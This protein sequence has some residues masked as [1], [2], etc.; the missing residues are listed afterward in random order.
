MKNL[1]DLIRYLKPERE[2]IDEAFNR[3]LDPLVLVDEN[4]DIND[5]FKLSNLTH[6]LREKLRDPSRYAP[7][8]IDINDPF[9]IYYDASSNKYYNKR[10]LIDSNGNETIQFRRIRPEGNNPAW[11]EIDENT[12][13]PIELTLGFSFYYG[14]NDDK[15]YQEPLDEVV[16]DNQF[17]YNPKELET[18][19]DGEV[20]EL[21]YKDYEGYYNDFGD[22]LLKTILDFSLIK[23]ISSIEKR[24]VKLNFSDRIGYVL[25]YPSIYSNSNNTKIKVR[26]TYSNIKRFFLFFLLSKTAIKLEFKSIYTYLSFVNAT[27]FEDGD[28]NDK[29]YFNTS[30]RYVKAFFEDYLSILDKEFDRRKNNITEILKLI[31]FTPPVYLIRKDSK[32][33]WEILERSLKNSVTNNGTNKEDAVIKIIKVLTLIESPDS[34]LDQLFERKIGSNSFFYL[35]Y[36]KINGENFDSYIAMI[37]SLWLKSSYS[38]NIEEKKYPK[39]NGPIYLSYTSN[40]TLGFYYSNCDIDYNKKQDLLDISLETGRYT[41]EYQDRGKTGPQLVRKEIILDYKYHPLYPIIIPNLEEQKTEIKLKSIVPAFYL[42]ANEDR[43]FWSNV[44]TTGEYALDIASTVSGVGNIYK[45]RHLAKVAARAN[46]LKNTTRAA[47][48]ANT[49]SKVQ[50]ISGLVEVSSGSINTLLKLLELEDSPIGK[51]IGEV[52]FWLEMASLTG[53]LSQGIRSGLRKSSINLLS[54]KEALDSFVQKG[55]L[56]AKKQKELIEDIILILLDKV[57]V[58]FLKYQAT[59]ELL[60]SLKVTISRNIDDLSS[61]PGLVAAGADGSRFRVNYNNLNILEGTKDDINDFLK[62]IDDISKSGGNVRKKITNKLDE[63][64][65]ELNNKYRDFLETNNLKIERPKGGRSNIQLVD[66]KNEDINFYGRPNE[67]E[68]F[69]RLFNN[70]EEKI[71]N[72]NI[73]VKHFQSSSARYAKEKILEDGTVLRFSKHTIPPISIDFKDTPQYIYGKK[74]DIPGVVTI[75]LTGNDDKDFEMAFRKSGLSTSE[76]EKIEE[77]G[78]WTWHHLDDFNPETGECTMQLVSREIHGKAKHAGG[79][80]L[81]KGTMRIGYPGRNNTIKY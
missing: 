22:N 4:Y 1:K 19:E 65:G 27:F 36:D 68:E 51:E 15:I 74:N 29:N 32:L 54:K 44:I 30:N 3:K 24:R 49:A 66:R 12:L 64:A 81:Y 78:E 14:M 58:I 40:K 34:F 69:I 21:N 53:E 5:P 25:K 37:F 28:S 75:K 39:T 61:N 17:K 47:R 60:K 45:F 38:K 18:L 72:Y 63:I 11:E 79:A 71:K 50:L 52:L 46:K 80:G 77:S 41:Y 13:T 73:A 9:I 48:F 6:V 26:F 55:L 10:S 2:Q 70:P 57:E 42:K 76:I 67:L 43:T 20:Y 31:L 23:T 16:V 59:I 35:L 62:K 33:L 8:E 56:T 7:I